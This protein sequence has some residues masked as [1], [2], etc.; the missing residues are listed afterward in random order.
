MVLPKTSSDLHRPQLQPGRR[1]TTRMMA[2]MG[3]PQRNEHVPVGLTQ[4]QV[5][6]TTTRRTGRRLRL[7]RTVAIN[8]PCQPG[9]QK[10]KKNRT[11]PAVAKTTPATGNGVGGTHAPAGTAPQVSQA[12]GQDAA[13]TQTQAETPTTAGGDGATITIIGHDELMQ[14][15]DDGGASALGKG[16]PAKTGQ[17]KRSAEEMKFEDNT[18]LAE[19]KS[20]LKGLGDFS[21]IPHEDTASYCSNKAKT[22]SSVQVVVSKSHFSFYCT[23][24]F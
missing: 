20:E 8:R 12:T 3:L 13:A 2:T 21:K 14:I 19:R 15:P 23:F 5:S 6:R 17:G 22:A 18:F 4:L 1:E 7:T 9:N 24:N 11:T 16:P 10:P